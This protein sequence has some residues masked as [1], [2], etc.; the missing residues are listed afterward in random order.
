[1]DELLDRLV[2]LENRVERAEAELQRPRAQAQTR[3]SGAEA[4][5]LLEA[6][7]R[8]VHRRARAAIAEL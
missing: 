2:S 8:A 1:L 5:D 6:R 4:A 3:E 7:R